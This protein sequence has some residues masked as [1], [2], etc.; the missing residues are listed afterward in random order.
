MGVDWGRELP[1]GKPWGV[2]YQ[3]IFR[4]KKG[5]FNLPKGDNSIITPIFHWITSIRHTTALRYRTALCVSKASP[6]DFYQ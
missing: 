4:V 2:V 6:E 5:L 1:L 3:E